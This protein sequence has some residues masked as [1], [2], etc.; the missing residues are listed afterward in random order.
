[1]VKKHQNRK[2][3]KNNHPFLASIGQG[4]GSPRAANPEHRAPPLPRPVPDPDIGQHR[5]PVGRNRE[6]QGTKP[7]PNPKTPPKKKRPDL[8]RC[9]FTHER[10]G[11]YTGC[12]SHLS[13]EPSCSFRRGTWD[14][15]SV[16]SA[17]AH[18]LFSAGLKRARISS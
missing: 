12:S 2:H 15:C 9:E 1:M 7:E 16:P 3:H 6:P 18:G 8:Y 11:C 14:R 10:C 4:Q 13:K 5:S 17:R